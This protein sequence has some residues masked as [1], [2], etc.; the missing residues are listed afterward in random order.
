MAHRHELPCYGRENVTVSRPWV[1]YI[2]KGNQ[3]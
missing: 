2:V 3:K 1:K